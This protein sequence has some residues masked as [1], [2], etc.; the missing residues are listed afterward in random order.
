MEKRNFLKILVLML[1]INIIIFSC[2]LYI[3]NEQ[4]NENKMAANNYLQKVDDCY[5][6]LG[7]IST[8]DSVNKDL[9]LRLLMVF[10]ELDTMAQYTDLDHSNYFSTKALLVE[11]MLKTNSLNN[12]DSNEITHIQN[13]FK[14]LLNE[15]SKID[16]ENIDSL[17]DVILS[18]LTIN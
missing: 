4:K 11:D 15:S 18:T 17:N 13:D 7:K 5:V 6:I 12:K 8:D 9:Y 16:R 14:A 3:M 10:K 1:L 2:L